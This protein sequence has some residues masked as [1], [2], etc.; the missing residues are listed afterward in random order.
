MEDRRDY[1]HYRERSRA[2]VYFARSLE[3]LA[4]ALA[5]LEKSRLVRFITA[6]LSMD[7]V[8]EVTARFGR[9]AGHRLSTFLSLIVAEPRLLAVIITG[10][11]LVVNLVVWLAGLFK[12]RRRHGR[13]SQR[14]MPG[15][16]KSGRFSGLLFIL[17]LAVFS[18]LFFIF[19]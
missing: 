12:N 1:H 11:L 14:S 16:A 17:C 15:P 2:G 4:I 6:K 5:Y 7:A 13:Y 18:A 19:T 8:V 3:L 9:S 10:I